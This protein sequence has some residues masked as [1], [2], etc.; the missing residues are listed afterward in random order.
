VPLEFN[1]SFIMPLL[2][3]LT[4]IYVFSFIEF[5]N[6]MNS[7]F[8]ADNRSKKHP[9]VNMNKIALTSSEIAGLWSTY[10]QDSMAK[11]ILQYFQHHVKDTEIHKVVTEALTLSQNHVMQITK[12]FHSE[13]FPI[14]HGFSESDINLSAKPLFHDPYVLSFVYGMS[15]M[16]MINY[17][18]ITSTI[19]RSDVL[20]FFVAA[21]KSTTDLYQRC[22]NLMLTKGIYDRPIKMNYPKQAEYIQKHGFISG[23][24]GHKR[25]LNAIELTEIFVRIERN[26]F[27]VI[28][29]LGFLQVVKD[30]EIKQYLIQGKGLCDE[31]I[32]WLNELLVKEDLLGT[33]PVTMEVAD[34]VESPFSDKLILSLIYLLNQIDISLV[35][36]ALSLSMRTD[37]S[38]HYSYLI[39][40]ILAYTKDG[41]D[42]MVDRQWLEQPPLAT[43][44]K[45]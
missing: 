44:R 38:A 27:A 33:V 21:N 42:L 3:I 43:D 22:V 15:R 31:Q 41:Y 39:T 6:G 14:P 4:L 35:G 30:K 11:C 23:M 9:E 2:L 26:Y 20:Q 5:D 29:L 16:G 45:E 36:H 8:T 24:L 17:P 18:F 32:N 37:L 12:I 40:K 25:P 28:L 19:S 7:N 13:S 10:I 34:S 1:H